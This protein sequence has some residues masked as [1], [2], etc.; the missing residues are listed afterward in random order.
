MATSI[1]RFLFKN[2]HYFKFS[3][4][5]VSARIKMVSPSV[6]RYTV[7]DVHRFLLDILA[8]GDESKEENVSDSDMLAY[9]KRIGYRLS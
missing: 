6:Q 8:N 9:C 3:E 1:W 4:C 7:E 5:F 2:V